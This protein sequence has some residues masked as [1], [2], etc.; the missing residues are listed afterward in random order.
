VENIRLGQSNLRVS[1][2]GLGAM[3]FGSPTWRPW[4]VEE[5]AARPIITRAYEQGITFFDTCDFYSAGRSEEVLG[6]V[7]KEIAPREDVV[8]A[9][10]VGNPMGPG[11]NRRG[12][13]R[14]HM[15]NAVEASLKRLDTDYIDLYQ[16][17]IWD[18]A[19][20]IDEMVGAFDDLI[21]S[22]KILYAGATDIPAWQTAK[23]VYGARSRNQHTF[24]S[25]QHHYNLLWREDERD[26]IPFCESEGLGLLPYSPMARGL[27]ADA[28]GFDRPTVRAQTDEYAE[29]W[30]GRTEDKSTAEKVLD[31]AKR[32]G[33]TPGQIAL[34]WVMTRSPNSAPI[35][36]ATTATQVD[37]AVAALDLTLDSGDLAF[38]EEGYSARLANGHS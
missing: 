25:V 4:V 3:S 2:L 24:A 19:T 26:L 27:L 21:R 37:E 7:L 30:Y 10:K 33:V 9:T 14:K 6:K 28:Q 38:L 23:A 20:D 17:H 34:A 16:T 1:K 22:G 32:L 29:I 5:D 18:P 36:G 13:S 15:I 31:L 11:V 12:Y 35:F 8:I